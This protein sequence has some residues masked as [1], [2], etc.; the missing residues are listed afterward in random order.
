MGKSINDEWNELVKQSSGLK[1][2]GRKLE[3]VTAGTVAVAVA[4]VVVEKTIDL[5][6]EYIEWTIASYDEVSNYD[7]IYN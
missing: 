3:V 7:E 5:V 1:S 4:P 6:R 2:R